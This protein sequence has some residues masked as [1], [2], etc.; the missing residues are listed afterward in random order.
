MLSIMVSFI[1]SSP[2]Y[3]A[4]GRPFARK[5][6]RLLGCNHL[7][8]NIDEGVFMTKVLVVEDNSDACTLMGEILRRE[9]LHVVTAADGIEGLER[10]SAELPDLIITDISMPRLTGREMIEKLRASPRHKDVPILA[11]TAYGIDRAMEAIKAGASR[12]LARPF[13]NHLLIAFVKDLLKNVGPRPH[14]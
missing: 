9:K 7:N 3:I 13:E 12:A 4:R 1:V 6:V 5:P 8:R 11:I 2:P 10:A 14:P